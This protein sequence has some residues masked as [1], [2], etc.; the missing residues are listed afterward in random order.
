MS[1]SVYDTRASAVN[2]DSLD[3]MKMIN[4]T[5]NVKEAEPRKT[6]KITKVLITEPYT[7]NTQTY[8]SGRD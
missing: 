7:T 2:I 1:S 6:N 3:L 4:N 5:L 8:P